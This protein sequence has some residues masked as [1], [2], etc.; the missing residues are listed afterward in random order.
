M[1]WSLSAS[2][3]V[4]EVAGEAAAAAEPEAKKLGAAALA[5]VEQEL[6]AELRKV[7]SNPKYHVLS[8]FFSGAHTGTVSD[9]HVPAAEQPEQPEQAAAP[10]DGGE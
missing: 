10:G 3:A 8:S 9:L 6:V 2:G 7:L 5:G 1:S 4:G